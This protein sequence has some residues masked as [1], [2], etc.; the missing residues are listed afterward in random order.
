[1]STTKQK[2]AARKNLEK[3]RAAGTKRKKNAKSSR[4]NELSTADK[5]KLPKK[6]FAF[7]DERKEP[8]NDAKHVRNAIA[9]FD[10]VEGVTDA[11]RDA[12]WKRIKKAAKKYDVDIDANGW[13]DL[14]KGGKAK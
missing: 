4:G 2:K 8:L 6:Q 14:M 5:N 1:M 7:P 9:R 3:A 11:E 13:R 12:A 10:Q